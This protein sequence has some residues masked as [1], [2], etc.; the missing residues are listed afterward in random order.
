[1]K[2]NLS[3]ILTTLVLGLSLAMAGAGEGKGSVQ[4]KTGKVKKVDVAAKQVTVMVTREMI[5]TVADK[6]KIVK[7]DAPKK[8]AD[9]KVDDQVSVE[10]VK[11]GETRTAQKIAILEN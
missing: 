2:K 1:M 3:L 4:T 9:I 6:T 5:F 7:G 11:D 8:L 10:Y